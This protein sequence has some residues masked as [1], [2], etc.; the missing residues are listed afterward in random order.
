MSAHQG[1]APV[2]KPA[3]GN[4]SD[5]H[6]SRK[7]DCR[8]G[9]DNRKPWNQSNGNFNNAGSNFQAQ[10][11]AAQ[12][13]G[14]HQQPQNS[15][16]NPNNPS[17]ARYTR[18]FRCAVPGCEETVSH[19]RKSCNVFL[20]LP[21]GARWDIVKQKRWFPWCLGHWADSECFSIQKLEKNNQKP[22]CGEGG[23]KQPHHPLLHH[24]QGNL[25]SLRLEV[26]E[27]PVD[28]SNNYSHVSVK[29]RC[30]LVP[31]IDV[32]VVGGVTAVV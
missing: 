12:S 6:K 13:Q 2:A 11:N 10:S 21:I 19:A 23:C 9:R 17:S 30:Y 32:V 27:R 22:E 1:A 18:E 3:G 14:T 7:D 29:S 28:A 8:G 16:S 5:G 25:S 26:T 31:Q 20:S 24:L 4:G 15:S